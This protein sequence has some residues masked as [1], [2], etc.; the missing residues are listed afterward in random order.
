MVSDNGLVSESVRGLIRSWLV[1]NL[2]L[3]A[4][5]PTI[6]SGGGELQLMP[7]FTLVI[8]VPINTCNTSLML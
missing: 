2:H 3:P 4:L 7:L 8:S 6:Y 1:L 5:Q